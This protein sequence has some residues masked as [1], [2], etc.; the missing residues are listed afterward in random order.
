[1]TVSNY[2]ISTEELLT[3]LF[4]E[5]NKKISIHDL[6]MWI[7]SKTEEKFVVVPREFCVLMVSFLEDQT[8]QKKGLLS[9]FQKVF[10]QIEEIKSYL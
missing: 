2:F 4:H 9:N 10:E 5:K 7:K 8:V 1:M 3:L 6:S